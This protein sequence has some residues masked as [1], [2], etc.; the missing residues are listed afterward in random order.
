MIVFLLTTIKCIEI[1][2]QELNAL[3]AKQFF[4]DIKLITDKD[5]GQLWGVNL[6]GNL[7][8]IDSQTKIAYANKNVPE[9]EWK[10]EEGVFIMQLPENAGISNTAMLINGEPW[11]TV[12]YDTHIENQFERTSL[13]I[14]ELFHQK[15]GILKIKPNY[16]LID[17][18]DNKDVRI[19]LFLEQQALLTA[20]E[21]EGTKRVEA[22]NDALLFRQYRYKLFADDIKNANAFEIHEGLAQYTGILL[23]N[24]PKSYNYK[25]L[26]NM[27]SQL[28]ESPSV[29]RSYAYLSGPLYGLLLKDI[30]NKW[31]HSVNDSSNL[32]DLLAQN[33][34]IN[35]IIKTQD[36]LINTAEKYDFYKIQKE[37]TN[38]EILVKK[39]YENNKKLF[40]EGKILILPQNFK[41]QFN[42]NNIS[43]LKGY[44]KI[45]Y[46]LN[47][48][49]DWGELIVNEQGALILDDWSAIHVPVPEN[50]NPNK[51]LNGKEWRLNLNNGYIIKQE[52]KNWTV[53]KEMISESPET[54]KI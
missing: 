9:G 25:N 40:V 23:S 32:G 53:V 4:S 12:I 2:S 15:Q 50:W 47:A 22:I 21:S 41:I 10:E 44:G 29:I 49:A 3:K 24:A 37:E 39:Q 11:S 52:G 35:I 42:P 6:Y 33:Y 31:E 26:K 16:N 38:R 45:Y 46:T 48:Q 51:G 36:E 5:N 14:H 30:N 17:N 7:I 1:Q 20:Y 8:I 34:K 27:F 28:K 43:P 19:W 13:M 18:M 54:N